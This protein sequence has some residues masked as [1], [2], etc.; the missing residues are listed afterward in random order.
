MKYKIYLKLTYLRDW[1][2]M[3]RK[4]VKLIDWVRYEFFYE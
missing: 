3:P 1:D 2:Y 4:I